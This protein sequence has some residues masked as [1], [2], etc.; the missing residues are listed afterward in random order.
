[1]AGNQSVKNKLSKSGVQQAA[2]NGSKKAI[3]Q[4]E[5][6][7]DSAAWQR[8]YFPLWVV[9]GPVGIPGSVGRR[10]WVV[11]FREEPEGRSSPSAWQPSRNG[12]QDE[13][14]H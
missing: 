7:G 1:M 13:R 4:L 12:E 2:E 10:T 3:G 14:Q 8:L 6:P 9:L 11:R 5:I